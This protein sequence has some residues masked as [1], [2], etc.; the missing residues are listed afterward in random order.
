MNERLEPSPISPSYI[1]LR[2]L[3]AQLRAELARRLDARSGLAVVDVGC[4]ERPYEELFDG[5]CAEYVGVDSRDG[6]RV[7]VVA[8]G[9]ALPFEDDRFDCAICTQLLEHA[10]DPTAVV[11]ELRRVLRPG[12]L[13]LVST[14]GVIRYHPNPDDY[15]RWT[16]TGLARL[17]EEAGEWASVDVYP[18]GGTASAIATLVAQQL[19]SAAEKLNRPRLAWPGVGALNASAWRLDRAYARH[20]PGR[21]PDL[22]PTYL[23]VAER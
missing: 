15:W 20:F 6:P 18:N 7:D 17:F 5:H 22:A 13:A 12:G 8:G 10:D 1:P 3:A 16:H 14:H 11:A 9:E 19:T 2:S 4:G 23:V 21:P